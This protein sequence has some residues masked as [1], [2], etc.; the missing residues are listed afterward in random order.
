MQLHPNLKLPDIGMYQFLKE[1]AGILLTEDCM[2]LEGDSTPVSANRA[3]H[4]HF[5]VAMARAANANAS[6][7]SEYASTLSYGLGPLKHEQ[8]LD[9]HSLVELKDRLQVHSFKIVFF[10][11][12]IGL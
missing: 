7:L 8:L 10:F 1:H 12:V 11:I 9:M 5:D 4:S 2:W 3:K 6:H